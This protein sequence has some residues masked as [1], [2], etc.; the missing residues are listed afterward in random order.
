[1]FSILFLKCDYYAVILQIQR[2]SIQ[3]GIKKVFI[4]INQ[5]PTFNSE[6]VSNCSKSQMVCETTMDVN[7]KAVGAKCFF[8]GFISLCSGGSPPKMSNELNVMLPLN[9]ENIRVPEGEADGNAADEEDG[10]Y[11]EFVTIKE[12]PAHEG[13]H[14]LYFFSAGFL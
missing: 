4:D 6:Y 14:V 3:R 13:K 8:I 5:I 1:M 11:S 10:K 9:M 7:L 12:D 2:F